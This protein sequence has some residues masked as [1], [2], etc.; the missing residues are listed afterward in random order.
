VRF[1]FAESNAA[2]AFS[3]SVKDE[4]KAFNAAVAASSNEV[5]VVI[6]LLIDG[7]VR[8]TAFVAMTTAVAMMVAA[9]SES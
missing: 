7:S 2:S 3:T 8:T 5:S 9:D 1:E 6:D 4:T